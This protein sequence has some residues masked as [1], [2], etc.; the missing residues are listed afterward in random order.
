MNINWD[1]LSLM[2][3]ND[4]RITFSA[5]LTLNKGSRTFHCL[6]VSVPRCSIDIY[7]TTPVDLYFTSHLLTWWTMLGTK[8]HML[9]SKNKKERIPVSK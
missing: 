5:S 4:R 7:N 9:L 8:P 6:T 2:I 3:T 1:V